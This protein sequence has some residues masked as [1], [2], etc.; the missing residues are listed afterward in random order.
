MAGQGEIDGAVGE[1]EHKVS[2]PLRIARWQFPCELSRV[3]KIDKACSRS[4][5]GRSEFRGLVRPRAESELE[6][7]RVRACPAD[8]AMH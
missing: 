5:G 6:A 7:L 3:G 2:D 1:R 4:G 8:I